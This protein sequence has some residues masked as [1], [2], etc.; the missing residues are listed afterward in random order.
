MTHVQLL[1]QG[2]AGV[3]GQALL[4]ALQGAHVAHVAPG[5]LAVEAQHLI[6]VLGAL[7]VLEVMQRLDQGVSGEH[8]QLQVVHDV[9]LTQ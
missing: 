1:P 8:R 7:P 9:L 2:R 5:H 4:L 6:V 3:L